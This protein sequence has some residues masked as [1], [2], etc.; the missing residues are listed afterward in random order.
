LE[1]VLAEP[2]KFL[3]QQFPNEIFSGRAQNFGTRHYGLTFYA[4]MVAISFNRPRD[5]LK[6]CYAMRARLSASHP[7]D[8]DNIDSSEI[9]YSDYF[10][11]ELRDELFLAS[12][13]FDFK[14]DTDNINKLV[15][16]L[17]KKDGFGYGELQS[18]IG[19][20][21][22][23]KASHKKVINFIKELWR[24]G[25]IGF[26]NNQSEIINFQ[27]IKNSPPLPYEKD[28]KELTFYLHRG[29]WWGIEKRRT[30]NQDI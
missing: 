14:A 2:T 21:F 26:K 20:F 19:E 11:K 28:L 22:N 4:Y 15:C 7:A 5:F 16:L 23:V 1:A 8:M 13:Y 30:L 18:L 12:K 29:I 24:Y 25:V 27:Y 3:V 9:E 17:G 10:L 6:F